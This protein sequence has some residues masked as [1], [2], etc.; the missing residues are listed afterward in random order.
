[1]FKVGVSLKRVYSC[2]D[3]GTGTSDVNDRS[4]CVSARDVTP[5]GNNV[6]ATSSAPKAKEISFFHRKSALISGVEPC[7]GGV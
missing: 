7:F 1:M 5:G 6:S 4:L 3:R 2:H